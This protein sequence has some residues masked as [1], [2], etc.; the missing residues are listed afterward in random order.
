M[1]T[2]LD[3]KLDFVKY[4]F[5]FYGNGGVYDMQATTEQIIMATAQLIS[6]ENYEF[7]ADSVDRERVRDI[8]ITSFGLK[9]PNR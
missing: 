4:V 7:C 9:F 5:G 1:A 2:D 8:M 6:R 3:F